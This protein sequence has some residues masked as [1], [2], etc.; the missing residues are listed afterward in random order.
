M[1]RMMTVIQAFLLAAATLTAQVTQP[2]VL[3]ASSARIDSA[4]RSID[5]LANLM[6]RYHNRFPVYDDV[7]SAGNHF[8]AYGLL[9]TAPS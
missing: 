3:I 4:H 7:S 9:G 8:H 1:T 5:Y 6:D 2:P